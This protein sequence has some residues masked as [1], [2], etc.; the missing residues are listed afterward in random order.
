MKKIAVFASG[1]G[2]NAE[3]LIKF[4][5]N[6]TNAKVV[7]VLSNNSDAK[8]LERAKSLAVDT[9]LFNREQLL[10][11]NVI[12]KAL[13]LYKVDFIV[14]AGFLWKFPEHII[15]EFEN[16]IVNIHPALL[17]DFGGKGMYGM[18]VHKA[19]IAAKVKE[20]GITIHQVNAQYDEGAIVF[21]AKCTVDPKDSADDVARKVHKLEMAHFPKIIKNI[22]L[23]DA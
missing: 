7:L 8:V 5:Q 22:L 11:P 4:F 15:K 16:K 14:L 3:N 6:D 19:V 23:S 17:P 21:Q 18:H 2:S 20:T 9:L 10:D 1:S 12:I 13:H